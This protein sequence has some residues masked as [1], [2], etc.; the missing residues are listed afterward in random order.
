MDAIA[1]N[2]A[3]SGDTSPVPPAPPNQPVPPNAPATFQPVT[4]SFS[5]GA[6]GGGVS[7]QAT[8]TLPSYA[9]AYAPAS[10]SANAQGLVATPNVDP[11]TQFVNLAEA[12]FSYRANLAVFRAASQ[13]EKAT[14]DLVA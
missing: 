5:A 4:V 2:I 11:A 1:S 10:P 8:P 14:L 12:T 9:T 3:N 6:S 7:A 13:M